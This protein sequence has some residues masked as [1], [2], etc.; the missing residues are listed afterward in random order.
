MPTPDIAE[1][2][3]S[4]ALQ[5]NAYAR[6]RT[7]NALQNVAM[8]CL[9]LTER[10]STLPLLN[11]SSLCHRYTLL[12]FASPLQNRSLLCPCWAGPNDSSARLCRT[13]RFHCF[14]F[15]VYA[16]P[17]L[18]SSMLCCRHTIHCFAVTQQCRSFRSF[19][20]TML[21]PAMPWQNPAVH[22]HHLYSNALPPITFPSESSSSQT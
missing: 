22:C 9:R 16:M 15:F 14:A 8:L 5:I 4:L 7:T 18:F 21:F 12:N 20:F 17:A 13:T 6:P 1:L 2:G 3:F 19:S 10:H 11:T